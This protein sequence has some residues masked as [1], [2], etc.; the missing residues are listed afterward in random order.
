M[1]TAAKQFH[2]CGSKD[3]VV[4]EETS[5]NLT[6]VS[7]RNGKPLRGGRAFIMS[8]ENASGHRVD[9]ARK[10]IPLRVVGVLERGRARWV[11]HTMFQFHFCRCSWCFAL[12]KFCRA[13]RGVWST[14]FWHFVLV[15][16]QK[17]YSCI[18][19]FTSVQSCPTPSVF[20]RHLCRQIGK[21]RQMRKNF[22][23]AQC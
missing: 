5:F 14:C 16:G 12:H 8:V 1:N 13:P 15:H 21:C 19:L 6:D 7:R 23:D 3:S 18:R 20:Q 17:L 4:A 22:F 10:K 11:S 9:V 2:C